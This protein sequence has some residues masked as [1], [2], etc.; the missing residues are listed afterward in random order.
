MKTTLYIMTFVCAGGI[1]AVAG[2]FMH[3]LFYRIPLFK[4]LLDFADRLTHG[5]FGRAVDAV[6]R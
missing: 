4:R 2:V 1:C 6:R 5:A 3:D